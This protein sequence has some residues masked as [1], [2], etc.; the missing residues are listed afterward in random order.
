ML[1]KPVI[2]IDFSGKPIQVPYVESGA[3]IGI[4]EEDALVS[5]IED[6]LYNEEACQ[7]LAK[8]REKFVSEGNYKPD[9]QASQRLADLITQMA[10]GR[11]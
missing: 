8:V 5:A 7:R 3:A 1:D 10:E 6:I 4:Y 2:V 11:E 9:G